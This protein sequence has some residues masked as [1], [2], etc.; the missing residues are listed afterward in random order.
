MEL[1]NNNAIL[2]N[3]ETTTYSI[4]INFEKLNKGLFRIKLI[5]QIKGERLL[6]QKY[7]CSKIKLY[8]NRK[9]INKYCHPFY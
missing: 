6:S 2:P 1:I 9:R 3:G 7:N 8:E 4:V 5:T